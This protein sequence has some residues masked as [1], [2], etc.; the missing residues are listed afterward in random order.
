MKIA[1]TREL[2]EF[3]DVAV[4][5]VHEREETADGLLAPRDFSRG[6]VA[7][8]RIPVQVDGNRDTG[9]ARGLEK[10][11]VPAMEHGLG[12]PKVGAEEVI[13][14]GERS[15][16]EGFE[17]KRGVVRVATEEM[18]MPGVI[19]QV[20]GGARRQIRDPGQVTVNAGSSQGLFQAASGFVLANLPD[21]GTFGAQARR[22]G[23]TVRAAA[24]NRFGNAV[25][26]SLAVRKE[27][28]AGPERSG[29]DVAIDVADDAQLRPAEDRFVEHR[30]QGYRAG[31]GSSSGSGRPFVS[32][33]K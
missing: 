9:F 33:R 28:F 16:V 24:T 23:R 6:R 15:E 1:L 13:G 32:G 17:R 30:P 31:C 8:F 2:S 7:P 10:L 27:I 14:G 22:D 19:H 11:F 20:H 12:E 29:L 18:P 21:E 25:N 3:A 4:G 5:H 26:R